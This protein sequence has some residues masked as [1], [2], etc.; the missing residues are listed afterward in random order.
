MK[1]VLSLKKN[2]DF[3]IVF[4]KHQSVANRQ[5]VVYYLKKEG[6]PYSRVGLSVSKKIG[7]AVTRNRVKRHIRESIHQFGKRFM[8]GFDCVIIARKPTADMS[9]HETL[10]SLSHVLKLAQVLTKGKG[11]RR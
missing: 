4:K 9:F 11:D 5:F 7:N 6:Q 3:Q 10:N 8:V 1:T 2:E